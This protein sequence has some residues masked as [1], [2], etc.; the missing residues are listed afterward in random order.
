MDTGSGFAAAVNR[1][2]R[3]FWAEQTPRTDELLHDEANV[4]LAL[5]FMNVEMKLRGISQTAR[6]TTI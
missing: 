3:E 4:H 1:R 5:L 2:N 6:L